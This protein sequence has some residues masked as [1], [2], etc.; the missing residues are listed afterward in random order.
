MRATFLAVVLGLA[1][2]TW[3]GITPSQVQAQ[4]DAGL[5]R[6]DTTRVAWHRGTHW[7]G[8]WYGWH[9]GS[10]Y[11]PWVGYWG[12]YYTPYYNSFYYPTYS[13]FYYP[14]YSSFYY[15]TYRSYYYPGY[16]TF[17]AGPTGLYFRF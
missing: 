12:G 5:H 8:G 16:A 2:L 15:P 11:R 4:P 6:A 13:N 17:Y 1:S 3:V 7:R 9:R 10:F 14:A